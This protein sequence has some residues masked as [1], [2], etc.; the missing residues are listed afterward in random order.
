MPEGTFSA[1]EIH[2]PTNLQFVR[3]VRKMLEGLLASEG[4]GE[5]DV[6]DAGL[7][8]TEV[9]QNAVEHGSK[10]DGAESVRV[11]CAFEGEGPDS[12]T[13]VTV[14]VCDP[15][16]GKGVQ[17]LLERDVTHPP[18]DDSARGR[19]LYLVHRMSQAMDRARGG[20]GGSL[21]RVRLRKDG[22]P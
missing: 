5:D 14:E 13:A 21:V 15:G 22:T 18:A 4:W 17:A 1:L 7:V 16:T 19:G 3:F 6:A 8:A 2:I 12:T 9:I 11:R 10:N 20:D